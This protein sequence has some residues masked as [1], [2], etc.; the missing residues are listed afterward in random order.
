MGLRI[1]GALG[2]RWRN[3]LWGRGL[4]AIRETFVHLNMQDGAK[5]KLSR[6][7]VEAPQLLLD[8]LAA[9]RRETMYADDH[10]FVFPSEKLHDN[11][12]RSA[13]QLV[14]DYIRPVAVA[15]GVIRVADGVTY[16]ND[17]ESVKRFGF[18][19]LGRHSLATQPNG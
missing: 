10:D 2:L 14:E 1:S 8:A 7:R 5:T 13:S 6:S 3:V 12:P 4:I 15:A 9:W 19:T 16:D 17:G 18:H 11:Q